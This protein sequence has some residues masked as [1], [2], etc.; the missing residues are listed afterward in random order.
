[1]VNTWCD[2]STTRRSHI[3][4]LWRRVGQWCSDNCAC[5]WALLVLLLSP[6]LCL[7]TDC[8]TATSE[9]FVWT[10]SFQWISWTGSQIGASQRARAFKWPSVGIWTRHENSKK[11]KLTLNTRMMH[12]NNRKKKCGILDTSCTHSTVAA[13]I[14]SWRGRGFQTLA[15][16]PCSPRLEPT[17]AKQGWAWSVPGWETSWEN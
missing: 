5:R 15:I 4:V 16:S 12:L 14:T 2:R 9:S 11:K 1:M 6:S 10:G 7:E 17:E 8:T 13:L 3:R